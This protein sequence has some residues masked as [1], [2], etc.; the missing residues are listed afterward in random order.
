MAGPAAS[1]RRLA[2]VALL[3]GTLLVG[4][5]VVEGVLRLYAAV[6]DTG[7]A[8]ALLLDP[9]EVHVEP[10]GTAG[11]RPRPLRTMEYGNGT[12]ASTNEQ[13]F[14]GPGVEAAKPAGVLRVVLLGG[15]TTFGWGVDD[16]GTIDAY[17]RAIVAERYP[18][19][20]VE[21]VNL[22]F[23]GYDSYQLLERFR[24]DALP[25]S[26][27]VVIVNSGVND[28]RNAWYRDL[29]PGDPR[30]LLY[31]ATI[32]QLRFE[33]QRGGPTLWTRAK[34]WFFLARVPGWIR[35]QWLDAAVG[36]DAVSGGPSE[37]YWD[38]L[39]YF[40]ANLEAIQ[41]LAHDAAAAVLLS[42]PP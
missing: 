14:R 26:P 6:A 10:H 7:L 25:L 28:V 38:A 23:E 40:A 12:S 4:L 13:G 32:E 24:S 17:M 20:V 19:R 9:Y 1:A 33:E 39:D 29:R 18:D 21:I 35:G 34:H 31:R 22:A 41:Q 8:E 5:G 42:T 37:Y 15:S 27:D 2:P 16:D 36:T 11:F 30:T 3:V